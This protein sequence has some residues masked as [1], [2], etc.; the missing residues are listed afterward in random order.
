MLYRIKSS[1]DNLKW[2]LQRTFRK[3]HLSDV[4]LWGANTTILRTIQ[5]FI[6]SA[7]LE[8]EVPVHFINNKI[9]SAK[10]QW[11]EILTEINFALEFYILDFDFENS[12]GENFLKKYDY[13]DIDFNN[14]WTDKTVKEMGT[15]AKIGFDLFHTHIHN[16]KNG[17][18]LFKKLAVIVG[19]FADIKKHSYPMAFKSKTDETGD[20]AIRVWN[21][22]LKDIASDLEFYSKE[23]CE[24]LSYK[25]IR[26]LNYFKEY[27]MDMWD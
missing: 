7:N 27:L 23:G 12:K 8:N 26:G 18:I 11:C 20:L 9:K 3:N 10:E 14:I 6:K 25:P 4:D 24:D 16:F 19:A 5:D 17:F 13:S 2:N 15:R 21:N 22:V 1:L